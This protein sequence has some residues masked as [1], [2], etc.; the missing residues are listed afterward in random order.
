MSLMVAPDTW[1]TGIGSSCHGQ[2]F[3][4][5]ALQVSE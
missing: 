1:H 2:H 3:N 4:C 5:E